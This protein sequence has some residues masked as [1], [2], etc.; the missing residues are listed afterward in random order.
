M[1][2]KRALTEPME[3]EAPITMVLAATFFVFLSNVY[4]QTHAAHGIGGRP[5]G[6]RSRV[7]VAGGDRHAGE[8]RATVTP[9]SP[10]TLVKAPSPMIW[11]PSFLGQPGGQ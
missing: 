10:T 5:Q 4:Q 1:A 11:A 3:P 9:A 6:T 7:T 8:R 2:N